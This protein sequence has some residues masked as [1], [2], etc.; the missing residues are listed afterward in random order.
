VGGGKSPELLVA[1]LIAFLHSAKS[2]FE[3]LLMQAKNVREE[4]QGRRFY[5][6]R[7][8]RHL[9]PAAAEPRPVHGIGDR[10]FY[11]VIGIQEGDGEERVM[12]K[13]DIG[14]NAGVIWYL[15]RKN[16]TLSIKEIGETRSFPR[17]VLICTLCY[18]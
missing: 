1:N 12:H 2:F 18:F 13:T 5:P 17:I 6:L 14:I 3:M 4:T 10:V 9:K 11:E 8:A 16:G 15:L 7:P